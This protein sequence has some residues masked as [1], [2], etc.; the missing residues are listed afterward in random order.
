[1]N[2]DMDFNIPI[3]GGGGFNFSATKPETLGSTEYTLV[4]ITVDVSMSVT[5]FAKE[6]LDA[7]KNVVLAC[8]DSDNVDKLLLRLVSFNRNIMEVHGF[9]PLVDINVDDYQDLQCSGV[10]SLFDAVFESIGA[11]L[12]YANKLS[13]QDLDVNSINF[14]ITDGG[15]NNST[16]TPNSIKTL[17][18]KTLVSEE[19]ESLMTILIG[20]NVSEYVQELEG[21]KN[22][23]NLSQFLDVGDATPKQLA[24]LAQFVSKSISSQSQSLGS[25]GV[26]QNLLF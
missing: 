4:T 5:Y 18:D 15:D 19:L 25:G 8:Q 11:S 10:T 24:R 12:S 21:F 13:D 1:M 14:I 23:A 2:E 9:I 20:I 3:V 6:L 26:S 16:E 7:V 17:V 22:D